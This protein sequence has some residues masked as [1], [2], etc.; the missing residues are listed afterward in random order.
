MPRTLIFNFPFKLYSYPLKPLFQISTVLKTLLSILVL[1]LISC[2][3]ER[4]TKQKAGSNESDFYQG[5]KVQLNL[6]D[7]SNE[8]SQAE[9][10]F[11]RSFQNEP[12]AW[13]LWNHQ[14]LEKAQKAQKPILAVTGD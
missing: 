5:K 10:D 9:T 4:K 7:L 2:E 3:S 14:V 11:L 1:T 12:I 6:G 13:Q 8:L